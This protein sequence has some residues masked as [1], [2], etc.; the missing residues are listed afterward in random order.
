MP[1]LSSSARGG[2]QLTT[3]DTDITVPRGNYYIILIERPSQDNIDS[4][5]L[6]IIQMKCNKN[7]EKSD[8]KISEL[9]YFVTLTMC[10]N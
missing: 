8:T 5:S 4:F 1:A 3:S 2:T 9:A 7:C 10:N 6:K